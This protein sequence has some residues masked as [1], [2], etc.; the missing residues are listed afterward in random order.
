MEPIEISFL[1]VATLEWSGD[2]VAIF[3]WRKTAALFD[4][5]Q[6][7][8][9]NNEKSTDFG[10]KKSIGALNTIFL[11]L[12]LVDF[13]RLSRE[14][15]LHSWFHLQ[16]EF[17]ARSPFDGVSTSELARLSAAGRSGSYATLIELID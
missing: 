5:R 6:I 11:G 7:R 17:S 15:V 9:L 4:H 13:K 10:L 1:S 12:M 14:W 8:P 3:N 2:Y 16:L